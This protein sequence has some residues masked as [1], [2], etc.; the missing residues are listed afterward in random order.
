MKL[1]SIFF[2]IALGLPTV[3]HAQDAQ[4]ET[5]K[6]ATSAVTD[7][8]DTTTGTVETES[9]AK[10]ESAPEDETPSKPWSLS[11]RTAFSVGSAAFASNE[12]IADYYESVG[13]SMTLGAGY[14]FEVLGQSLRA[15]FSFP[16][17]VA[18]QDEVNSN[19]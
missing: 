8:N 18:L 5:S 6:P 19:P 10:D 12:Y 3:G 9:G 1:R 15:G 13:M 17:R 2:T 14:S 16:F 11:A 4:S 7:V